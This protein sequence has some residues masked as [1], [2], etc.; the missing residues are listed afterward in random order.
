VRFGREQAA[1]A[2]S[3][4]VKARG[5][6]KHCFDRP[7]AFRVWRARF[8]FKPF[9]IKPHGAKFDARAAIFSQP[10]KHSRAVNTGI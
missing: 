7:R 8:Q 9:V 6:S 1:R 5:R 4:E 10:I 2:I 3:D